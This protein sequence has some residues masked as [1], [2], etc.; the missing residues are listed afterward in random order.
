MLSLSLPQMD[1]KVMDKKV[2][3]KHQMFSR[4]TFVNSFTAIIVASM[5]GGCASTSQKDSE[6]LGNVKYIEGSAADGSDSDRQAREQAESQAKE[7]E[8]RA[9]E[10]AD[11]RAKAEEDAALARAEADRLKEEMAQRDSAANQDDPRVTGGNVPGAEDKASIPSELSIFFGYDEYQIQAK[12]NYLVSKHAN[13]MMDNPD[14]TVR[15][16][17]NCDERG[18]REY[19]L[20]LG[21]KR[22]QSVKKALVGL[23]INER[24]IE[25]ISYGKEKPIAFGSDEESYRLN[26]RVD[27][28]YR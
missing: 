28:V 21:A 6:F 3:E 25:A 8:R 15:L 13:Y 22:S 19:N 7:A 24:R 14:I 2:F 11:R 18:G 27:I 9:Q 12:Y 4:A 16:E 17:G 1:K 26:R 10:E 23:G 5:I 20:A